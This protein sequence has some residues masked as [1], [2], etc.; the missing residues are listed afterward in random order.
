MKSK[1]KIYVIQKH[2]ASHL[3]Y[4]IRLEI[5]GILKS[6]AIPKMPSKERRIKRLVVQTKDHPIEYVDFEC[7][8]HKV[9]YGAGT[10][11][12]WD[13]RTYKNEEKD[14]LVM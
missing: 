7:I 13:R 5:N 14:K 2:H 6:W 12:I 8:I 9:N 1:N 4:D 10:I 11:E 3:H